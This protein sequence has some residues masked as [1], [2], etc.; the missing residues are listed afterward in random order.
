[1]GRGSTEYSGAQL[2]VQRLGR[3]AHGTKLVQ[4]SA[5]VDLTVQAAAG[6]RFEHWRVGDYATSADGRSMYM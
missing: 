5:A 6:D 2:G 3:L 4:A 1:V